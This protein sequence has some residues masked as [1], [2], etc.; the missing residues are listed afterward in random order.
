MLYLDSSSRFDLHSTYYDTSRAPVL[1]RVGACLFP[2]DAVANPG[3]VAIESPFV[4][5]CR[6]TT[7]QAFSLLELLIMVML[8]RIMLTVS[9]RALLFARRIAHVRDAP[10][11]F[12]AKLRTTVPSSD[13]TCQT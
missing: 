12:T 5:R 9:T 3:L 13:V 7:R 1:P 2:N 10:D 6:L 4:R 11:T 8:V